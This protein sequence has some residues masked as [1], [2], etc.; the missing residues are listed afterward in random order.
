[1]TPEE[2]GER[3]RIALDTAVE[4]LDAMETRYFSHEGKVTDERM[5]ADHQAQLKAVR[6]IQ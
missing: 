3:L 6:E 2:L 5:V 4:K 1:M